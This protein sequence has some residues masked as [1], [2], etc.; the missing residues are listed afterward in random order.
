MKK[1]ENGPREFTAWSMRRMPIAL[2]NRL[3]ACSWQMPIAGWHP[4]G[5]MAL[6][7]TKVLEAG[8]PVI[9]KQLAEDIAK[10]R[11]ASCQK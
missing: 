9:E 3:R 5:S 4:S 2:L 1:M 7:V 8:I 11:K 10:G 6:M